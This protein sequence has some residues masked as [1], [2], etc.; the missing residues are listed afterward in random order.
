MNVRAA[1]ASGL[2]A[3]AAAL[4]LVLVVPASADARTVGYPPPP[5]RGEVIHFTQLPACADLETADLPGALDGIG[6]GW[7]GSWRAIWNT[8]TDAAE[9][10]LSIPC[11]TGSAIVLRYF[12]NRLQGTT[13]SGQRPT[14]A[15][16]AAT[17]RAADGSVSNY[18]QIGTQLGFLAPN[19]G[20]TMASRN[21]QLDGLSTCVNV[22]SI[23]VAIQSYIGAELQP[24]QSAEWKPLNWISDSGGFEPATTVGE[25]TPDGVELPIVCVINST[26]ADPLEVIQNVLISIA[27]LPG[28]LLIPVGWD[29]AGKLESAIEDGALGDV[30]DAIDAA[31]PDGLTCGLLATIPLWSGNSVSLDTCS[32]DLAPT[33]VKVVVGYV[34]VLGLCVLIVKRVFWAVGSK[35]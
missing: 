7:T 13:Q 2:A 3:T 11:Q 10:A 1:V 18:N 15:A 20:Q 31:V 30:A 19:V 12:V 21:L 35:G 5:S 14:F 4:A 29:R 16:I 17:C 25:L 8:G 34:M 26:G 22:V 6:L 27:G 23:R 32:V 28:C 9:Y 24:A 33:F